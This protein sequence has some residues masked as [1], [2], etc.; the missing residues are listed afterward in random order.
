MDGRGR[1]RRGRGGRPM[2]RDERER[3]TKDWSGISDARGSL[4]AKGGD[5]MLAESFDTALPAFHKRSS[6]TQDK[7]YRRNVTHK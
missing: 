4:C 6:V 7:V 1:R 2:E 3:K 5:C